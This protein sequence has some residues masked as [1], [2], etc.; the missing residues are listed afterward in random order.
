MV[1][2]ACLGWIPVEF[3]AGRV[4]V[5]GQQQIRDT[6][7]VTPSGTCS[8]PCASSPECNVHSGLTGITPG[9]SWVGCPPG[10]V[11]SMESGSVHVPLQ[12]L[13]LLDSSQEFPHR[14]SWTL[15]VAGIRHHVYTCFPVTPAHSGLLLGIPVSELCG[16]VGVWDEA[17][18]V[19]ASGCSGEFLCQHPSNG[20]LG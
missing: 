12:F 15:L 11:D 19:C 3:C 5:L 2:G 18:C 16:P 1:P 8:I 6:L 9:N 10:L 13:S 4:R 17:L 20:D 14:C 7:Q